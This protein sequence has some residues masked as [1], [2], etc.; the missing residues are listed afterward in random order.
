[1]S[2]LP[3]IIFSTLEE[4]KKEQSDTET[5]LQQLA[6]GQSVKA[7][8]KRKWIRTQDRIRSITLEYNIYKNEN[9]LLDY[10]RTLGHNFNL[11]Y[12][13]FLQVQDMFHFKL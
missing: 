10:L 9:R 1:M 13:K 3:V 8:P 6:L 4:L 2:N 7:K 11:I 5:A 12:E